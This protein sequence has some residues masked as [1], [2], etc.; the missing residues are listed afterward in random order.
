MNKLKLLLVITFFFFSSVALAQ[1][2]LKLMRRVVV[3]PVSAPKS[4]EK[5]AE[6]AWWKVREILTKDKRYL[7]ASKSFLIKKS[8]FQP[9]Q[10][11]T[12]ADAI[13]LGRLLD[14]HILV[15]SYVEKNKFWMK[16]YDT[17]YGRPIWSKSISLFSSIPK[18][19]QITKVYENLMKDFVAA[20]PYQGYVV[21]DS[22]IG[23]P[24]FKEG[25]TPFVKVDVGLHSQIEVGD[26]VQFI[27]AQN[28]SYEEFL[29]PNMQIRVFAEGKV[30]SKSRNIVDVQLIRATNLKD[31]KKY[32][33]VRLPKELMRLR[34]DYS[35]RSDSVRYVE[36]NFR[37]GSRVEDEEKIKEKRPLITSLSFVF[38]IATIM[39]LGF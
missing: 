20:V 23:S 1:M 38:N 9:R 8:V 36:Q 39:L 19:Q 35:L 7:V 37:F 32:T 24:V 21:V 16:V 31:I 29:S 28:D 11:L 33:L 6:E 30:F 14:A 17:E 34:K 15:T 25:E 26:P 5:Q 22:L 13:L 10:D 4:L 27:V 18:S 12:P 3:F 2:N